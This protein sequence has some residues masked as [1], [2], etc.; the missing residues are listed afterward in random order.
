MRGPT[1]LVRIQSCAPV[2]RA[3]SPIGRRHD[4]QTVG[5]VGSNPSPRTNYGRLAEWSNALGWKPGEL[6]N[7]LRRFKSC[8]VRQSRLGGRVAY[9]AGFE[10]R[11]PERPVGSN[12]T[13]AAGRVAEWADCA[14]LENRSALTG[15]A[16]SNRAPTASFRKGGRVVDCGSLLNC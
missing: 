7:G 13:P 6:G 8:A 14:C 11:R 5:S 2:S 4:V 3:G 15:T 1:V 9:C 12:P 16:R 10:Y